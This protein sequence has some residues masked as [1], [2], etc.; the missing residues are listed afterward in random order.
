MAPLRIPPRYRP[1]LTDV[2]ALSDTD[3]AAMTVALAEVPSHLAVSKL[4]DRVRQVLPDTNVDADAI[5]EAV[6][7][8]VLLLPEDG[9]GAEALARDV[10]ESDLGIAAEKRDSYVAH[11]AGL[12]GLRSMFLT[13]RA[14][15]LGVEHQG[16][17]HDVRFLTDLRPV[18]G[19]DVNA[20][21]QAAIITTSMKLEYHPGGMGDVEPIFVA[22]GRADLEHL[23]RSVKR[24]LSKVDELEK[25]I[26]AANLPYWDEQ[27]HSHDA[28]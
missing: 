25:F 11:L 28:S 12:L 10:S 24:A 16:V 19:T 9:D 3:I 18:F 2:D 23:E 13:A 8:L 27:G 7:S 26:T 1:G 14:T 4:A 21:L 5:L 15:G 17:F 6:L 20:G 22:L